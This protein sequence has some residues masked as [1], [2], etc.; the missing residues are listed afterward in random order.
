MLTG[1]IRDRGRAIGWVLFFS[2]IILAWWIMFT[3]A[4]M[5]GLS[6]FGKAVEANMMPMRGVHVLFPMWAIMMLAMMGPTLV[7]VLVS[8]ET[9]IRSGHANRT[10][11]TGL[12]AGYAFAWF[13]FAG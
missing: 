1:G 7:P 5:S 8:F 11:W 4:G 2:G 12:I 9:L 3:M 10:G 6:M 13:G